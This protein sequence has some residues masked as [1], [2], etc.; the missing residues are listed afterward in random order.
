MRNLKLF[1]NRPQFGNQQN[2]PQP[3]HVP[4][5]R[6]RIAPAQSAPPRPLQTFLIRKL[7][8]R[9][10]PTHPDSL[11]SPSHWFMRRPSAATVMCLTVSM[12][13]CSCAHPDDLHACRFVWGMMRRAYGKQGRRSG[14]MAPGLAGIVE[15]VCMHRTTSV[16][17]Y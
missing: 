15:M 1:Q 6:P 9:R 14:I 17:W 2:V 10:S 13:T 7:C 5:I 16:H 11:V 3:K 12:L 4:H 8:V